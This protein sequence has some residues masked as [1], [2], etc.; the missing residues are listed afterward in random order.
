MPQIDVDQPTYDAIRIAANAAGVPMGVIVARA[1]AAFA[2]ETPPGTADPWTEV[3]IYA[4][5]LGQRV[6]GRFLPATRRVVLT[7]GPLAGR[8]FPSPS[9]AAAAVIRETNPA[10]DARTNGWRFFHVASS[11]QHLDVLRSSPAP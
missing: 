11:G 5:Y 9:A 4:E 3:R 2:R 10:R 7:S 8:D 1:L 6:E